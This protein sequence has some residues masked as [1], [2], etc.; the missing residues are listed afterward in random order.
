MKSV[1][2]EFQSI[3]SL[4]SGI[5]V[6]MSLFVSWF[7]AT[8][9]IGYG[10]KITYSAN[11]WDVMGNEV[12]WVGPVGP[13]FTMIGGILMI[14][15]AVA[16]FILQRASLDSEEAFD[17]LGMAAR[18]A[19]VFTLFGVMFFMFDARD[20]GCGS[21]LPVDWIGVG[22]WLAI[23]FAI[24]GVF[25]GITK[26]RQT[27]TAPQRAEIPGIIGRGGT[28]GRSTKRERL[29]RR[30]EENKSSQHIAGDLGL[31][32]DHFNRAGDYESRGQDEQAITAY[33]DAIKADPNY[34]LP[35]FYRGSLYSIKDKKA[36]A[37]EDFEKVI[38]LSGDS[39]LVSMAQKR[40]QKLNEPDK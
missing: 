24:F 1:L 22:P 21:F 31:A 29:E 34:V 13:V 39:D 2:A 11:G 4:I 25:V 8:L 27:M 33:T 26:P 15:C 40:I 35:Y 32:K 38:E 20:T 5:V 3:I 16:A 10:M 28:P 9:Y 17:L 12:P 36:E 30:G 14:L 19:P 6:V 18:I 7:S 37:L 23:P